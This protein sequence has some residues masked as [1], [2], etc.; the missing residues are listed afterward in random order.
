MEQN[1]YP[2]GSLIQVT[3]YSPFRGLKGTI[4]V[5]DTIVDD[6]EEPFCFYQIVLEGVQ[7]KEPMWFECDEVGLVTSPLTPLEA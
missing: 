2:P 1:V 6:L 7:L 3:S 5:V 4:Q